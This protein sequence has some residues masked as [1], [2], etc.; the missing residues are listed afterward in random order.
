[1]SAPCSEMH[2]IE[3]RNSKES[4]KRRLELGALAT[5]SIAMTSLVAFAAWRSAEATIALLLLPLLMNLAPWRWWPAVLAFTYFIV[6]NRDIPV[7]VDRFFEDLGTGAGIAAAVTLAAI[8]SLPFLLYSPTSSPT[9]RTWRMAAALVLLTIPPVGL[10]A[11]R[12]PLLVSGL[13]FPGMGYAGVAASIALFAGV[14]GGGASLQRHRRLPSALTFLAAVLAV[15]ALTQ[16]SA[17]PPPRSVPGWFAVDTQF[18][19]ST[20][21]GNAPSRGAQVSELVDTLLGD[22]GP[23]APEVL[24][25]PESTFSPMR[26]VDTFMM[27]FVDER[28]RRSGATVLVGDVVVMEGDRWRNTV[29]A[30]GLTTGTVDES[31]LPMPMGNWRPGFGGVRSRPFSS[32]LVTI[33]TRSGDKAVAMSICFEDTVLWPHFGLLSGR[34]DVMVS[35]ANVWALTDTSADRTQTVSAALIA[36]LAGTPLVRAKNTLDVDT[37]GKDRS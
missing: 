36:R 33:T 13:L 9:G 11:W 19:P 21:P 4:L 10:V 37:Y 35:V 16:H 34:A 7:I 31:R 18:A 30:Y 12:S 20:E 28:A 5:I 14:A 32:D 26:P 3:S 24:V 2:E 17:S 6:G 29:R 27:N 8:Q 25:F 15:V 23:A 22:Q 1:M